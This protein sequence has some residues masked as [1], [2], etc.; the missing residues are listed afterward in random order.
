MLPSV[1]AAFAPGT[2]PDSTAM[3]PFAHRADTT[4]VRSSAAPL[5][6][7]VLIGNS[8]TWNGHAGYHAGNA[9]KHQDSPRTARKAPPGWVDSA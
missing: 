8:S 3:L 4:N 2:T 9:Q 5:E 1:I 7:S 6:I